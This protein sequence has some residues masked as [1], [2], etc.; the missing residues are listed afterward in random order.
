MITGLRPVEHFSELV[1]TAMEHQKVAAGELARTYLSTL[2]C[3]FVTAER[4][5][6]EPL[7]VRYLTALGSGPAEQTLRFK[8][9]G[10]LALFIAG[11]FSDSLR[12]KII[13]ID[14]YIVLGESS[15]GRL[16][17]LHGETLTAPAPE[18]LFTE[19]A[20]KFK[21]FVGILTEVSERSRLT[22][23][24]D[25]LRVYER[26]LRTGSPQAEK[27]LRDLGIDPVEINTDPV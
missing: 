18:A 23:A 26:W 22:S 21:L 7:A 6:D 12:R 27:L 15:Y 17:D 10:D 5:N 11:F 14:Y 24:R 3:D 9:L 25:V 13:D 8:Q 4:L 20:G 16:A 1:S 2:L 19:L